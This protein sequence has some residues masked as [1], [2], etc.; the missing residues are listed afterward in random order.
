MSNFATSKKLYRA[1][2]RS[3]DIDAWWS[4]NRDSLRANQ[5]KSDSVDGTMATIYDAWVSKK[6]K[7]GQ[8]LAFDKTSDD[9]R[10]KIE[11]NGISL[12]ESGWTLF[13][14]V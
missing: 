11:D 1:I 14:M 9:G 6:G 12:N 8:G 3:D 10:M 2:T 7:F 13:S 5:V 4:F